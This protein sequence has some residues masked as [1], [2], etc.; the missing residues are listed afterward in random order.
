MTES[1]QHRKPREIKS[2][3][4]E[5]YVSNYQGHGHKVS[6]VILSRVLASTTGMKFFSPLFRMKIFLIIYIAAITVQAASVLSPELKENI[7]TVDKNGYTALLLSVLQRNIRRTK[8]LLECG[9][10]INC[11]DKFGKTTLYYSAFQSDVETTELLLESGANIEM[12]K[13]CGKV[14]HASNDLRITKLLLKKGANIDAINIYGQTVLHLCV[15]YRSMYMT[16][17]LIENGANI[18]AL[19]KDGRTALHISVVYGIGYYS[20]TQLLLSLG[21][22]IETITEENR[23]MVSKKI[24]FNI[25]E[26]R[27]LQI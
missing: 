24:G 14:L 5:Y 13:E 6:K 8:F 22:K 4:H 9:A 11:I 15:I 7:N 19:D 16:K 1:G 20:I 27:K 17:F 3:N 26:I 12:P 23:K 10:D 2:Q 21:A 25:S 18:E